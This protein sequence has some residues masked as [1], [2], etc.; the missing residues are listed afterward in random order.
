MN[1]KKR[2]EAFS[3]LSEYLLNFQINNTAINDNLANAIELATIHNKWFTIE[4]INY[5]IT[6][7]A[8]SIKKEAIENWIRK[9]NIEENKLS[10]A[11]I[12]VVMA[13]NLPLVGFH[14]FFYILLSGNHIIAKL[15]SDDKYL[16]PAIAEKLIEIEPCFFDLISFT[17]QKLENFDAIIATGS[18]NTA[19]YFEYYFGNYP[20][21]IR[22]SRNGLAV[23]NGKETKDEISALCHDITRYFGMGCRS[24]SKLFVPRDY[25]FNNLLDALTQHMHILDTSKYYNNYEYFKSIYLINLLPFYDNGSTILKEE[26][27]ISSPISVV[28]YEFYDNIETV[29]LFLNQNSEQIQCVVSNISSVKT[30]IPFGNAQ[31][32]GLNDYADNVDVM[33]FLLNLDIENSTSKDRNSKDKNS[34]KIN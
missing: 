33:K 12:G 32:P 2:I 30:A 28:Y 18:N 19:R 25:N 22:K 20:H 7:I 34:K 16:M 24:V 29:N 21:I 14:D 5:S 1:L 4:N 27:L 8:N 26:K 13:G 15:S 10:P 6:S 17:A 31:S 23:L 11:K 9:Y 3:K